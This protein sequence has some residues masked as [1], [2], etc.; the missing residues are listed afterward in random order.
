MSATDHIAPVVFEREKMELFW[1][2]RR[3]RLAAFASAHQLLAGKSTSDPSFQVNLAAAREMKNSEFQK[4]R[5]SVSETP[6]FSDSQKDELIARARAVIAPDEAPVEA[7]PID[8][9]RAMRDKVRASYS[10]VSHTLSL[11]QRMEARRQIAELS[12]L[13]YRAELA[14]AVSTATEHAPAVARA[15]LLS[16]EARAI[17]E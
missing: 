8:A 1:G 5:H 4:F 12:S 16:T 11:P 14:H 10:A 6:G 15:A 2:A 9:V 13:V 17:V 3:K 7:T